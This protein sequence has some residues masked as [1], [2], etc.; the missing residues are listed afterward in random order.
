MSR[1]GGSARRTGFTLIELLVVIAIIA[2]LIGLLL[3]AVQK[4]REAAARMETSN[5]LKQIALGAH[6]YADAAEDQARRTLN[7]IRAMIA[8]GAIDP[9]ALGQHEADYDMLALNLETLLDDMRALAPT[10]ET[11]QDR[12][13]LRQGI[14]ATSELLASVKSARFIVGVLAEDAP[15]VPDIGRITDMLKLRLAQ[16]EAIKVPT[17][18]FA[19]AIHALP[20]G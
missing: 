13:L 8:K 14:L 5:N 2:I 19:A 16:I 12:R 6:N 17:G 9:V 15:P 7:A 20:G 1:L 11:A 3:P 18:A 10:L 4:V